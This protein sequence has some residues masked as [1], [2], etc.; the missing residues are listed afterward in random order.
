MGWGTDPV[1]GA[2]AQGGWGKDPVAPGYRPIPAETRP[3]AEVEAELAQREAA[4]NA[5][6]DKLNILEPIRE[7]TRVAGRA[8][9]A[10][11][12][13]MAGFGTML[14]QGV[15]APLSWGVGTDIRGPF[16]RWGDATRQPELAPQNNN[17]QIIDT[18]MEFAGGA[19][20]GVGVGSALARVA[21][22]AAPTVANRVGQVL[23]DLPGR[24][25]IGSQT[26]AVATEGVRRR[27]GGP[28]AQTMAG[29]VAGGAPFIGAP[30]IH[31]AS[32]GGAQL[33]G[34]TVARLRE[35][36]FMIP[37]DVAKAKL[38][39]ESPPGV[40]PSVPGHVVSGFINRGPLHEAMT[41]ENAKVVQGLTA[42]EFGLPTGVPVTP[43]TL[44]AVAAAQNP[45]YDIVTQTIPQLD[46]TG[47][48][49]VF[50]QIGAM[51]RNNPLLG[52]I[53]KVEQFRQQL[54]EV[55]VVSTRQVLDA[56]R[57]WRA[58]AS[59]YFNATGGDAVVNAQTARA[60]RSAAD[61]LENEIGAQL[62][63]TGN[64]HVFR[65]F[66]NARTIQAKVHNVLDSWRGEHLDPQQLARL[67]DE[68]VLLTGNLAAIADGARNAPDVVRSPTGSTLASP[69]AGYGGHI[70][71]VAESELR[72][73]LFDKWGIRHLISDRFQN[74]YGT[75]ALHSPNAIAPPSMPF[76]DPNVGP[77]VPPP[78]GNF[79]DGR[80][81]S[82]PAGEGPLMPEPGPF[83]PDPG[84]APRGPN[85]PRGF[86]PTGHPRAG[87]RGQTADSLRVAPDNAHEL[88]GGL[89]D[90]LG[91]EAP[92]NPVTGL[93]PALQAIADLVAGIDNGGGGNPLQSL[94]DAFG[95]GDRPAG[96][97]APPKGSAGL[98]GIKD[99]LAMQDQPQGAA[100]PT[101]FPEGDLASSLDLFGEP[102]PEAPAAVPAK[103]KRPAPAAPAEAPLGETVA[104]EGGLSG[105]LQRFRE[106]QGVD[107][108][109]Y[110]QR[111]AAALGDTSNPLNAAIAKL[112]QTAKEAPL[113]DTMALEDA[114]PRPAPA[115]LSVDPVGPPLP[116]SKGKT[117][118]GMDIHEN[119]E[120]NTLPGMTTRKGDVVLKGE[121]GRHV[122][123]EPVGKDRLVMRWTVVDEAHQGQGFGKSQAVDAV[124]YANDHGKMLDSDGSITEKQIWVWKSLFRDG[125]VR[126]GREPDWATMEAAA[127][128]NGGI[129]KKAGGE[130]WIRGIRL[131]PTE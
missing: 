82:A 29:L 73:L 88:P 77:P 9:G 66:E 17:E 59:R 12:R 25:L 110:Q 36:G 94:V 37:P 54:S 65:Q 67:G 8:A 11:S 68:G 72:R 15:T 34:D 1:V 71:P 44:E 129:A 87:G 112:E 127:K 120:P 22:G 130:S 60:Y 39:L 23:S 76:G 85:D 115:E 30:G 43:A 89:G 24:Q 92:P 33:A 117:A 106:A 21:P 79:P 111:V 38:A 27:G 90:I 28:L 52:P 95:L 55:G 5:T 42:D 128:D 40:Q 45:A 96:P 116:K 7:G 113:G 32:P 99:E 49:S 58:D 35:Y 10:L 123:L 48:Q 119:V 41:I 107:E 84:P 81:P 13:G 124:R 122:I 121:H 51:R 83:G 100:G 50:D 18:A 46:T 61:A 56:I 109:Q 75:P 4:A 57:E 101:D 104:A 6:Q 3:R 91:G 125:R 63:A 31:P 62:Q 20:T 114:P 103:P 64:E 69:S 2:P 80:F 19:A 108:G 26:G 102:P 86:N 16:Q 70:A 97:M 98:R 74:Q 131:G 118:S 53:P 78:G 93:P 14:E 105:V 47:V 126:A